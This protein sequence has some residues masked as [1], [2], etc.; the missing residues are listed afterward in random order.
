M[1]P[2][3]TFIA[4]LKISVKIWLCMLAIALTLSLFIG[5]FSSWY[6]MKLY[7][8]DTYEQTADSLQIGSQALTDSY[9][10][11]LNNVIDFASS[12][13]FTELVTDAYYNNTGDLIKNRAMIQ[14]PLSYLKYSSSYLDSIAIIGKNGEYYSLF[15]DSLKKQFLPSKFFGWE[16]SAIQG[17]TWYP[18]TENPFIRSK[19]IIPLV[20]P[21]ALF[22]NGRYLNISASF[23]DSDVLI[24]LMLDP[25]KLSQRLSLSNSSYTDRVLYIADANGQ[26]INLSTQSE[27]YPLFNESEITTLIAENTQEGI[28]LLKDHSNY[29]LYSRPLDFCGLTLMEILPKTSLHRRLFRMNTFIFF[30]VI[31]GLVM[32]A[33]LSYLLS[34]FVT[35]PFKRLIQNVQNIENNNYDVP[36]QMKYHDEIGRLN[37]AINSMYTTIQN[38]F[39]HIKVSE[40]AKYRSEIQLLSEQINPH[41]LYNTLECINMEVVGGHTEAAVLMIRNLGE[42]LRI[43]LNYGNEVIPLSKELTHVKAYIDIMNYRFCRKV[44]LICTVS[45]E[46]EYLPVL[47]QILQPLAEN[48]IRHGFHQ[49]PG[50]GNQILMPEISIRVYGEHP[51]IILEISD[52]GRGIDIEKAERA[53]YAENHRETPSQH[54]GLRNIYQRLSAY[55]GAVHFSFETIPYYKNTVQITISSIS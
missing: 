33:A 7:R 44:N 47:K 26:S 6:F 17:I 45:E 38:Q 29:S 15:T 37:D 35:R 36:C 32:A 21:I 46:L 34:R 3:I 40:R 19:E 48:C 10:N 53:L 22:S 11:L 39:E 42:F 41:F 24:I 28:R 49:D 8:E 27:F 54:V 25:K 55:Y 52:N 9:N 50:Y 1:K 20:I 12:P 23:E 51:Y 16:A 13:V 31:L 18:M 4:N 30:L 5:M 43:G 14:E 2:F